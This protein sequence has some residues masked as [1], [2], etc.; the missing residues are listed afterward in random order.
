MKKI[1]IA[2]IAHSCRAGGSLLG[3]L[4]IIRALKNVVRGEQVLLICPAGYGFEEIKLPPDS[5]RFSYKGRHSPVQRCW[6]D[7]ITLPKLVAQYRPDVIF[8]ISNEGIRKPSVPQVLM[9]HNSYPLYSKKHCP[10]VSLKERLRFALL[11]SQI[12]KSLPSTQLVFTQTPVVKQR[13]ASSFSYPESQIKVLPWPVPSEIKPTAG[14]KLPSVFDKTS[15]IFYVLVLT[16]YMGHRS[17][18]VL[19]RLCRDF[20]GELR[21]QNIRFITTVEPDDYPGAKG[22]L[23]GITRNHLQDIITNVGSI[24]REEVLRYYSHSN[25]LWLPTLM[26]TLCLPYLEAVRMEVP[27]M[28][29]D[30]DFARY[31]CGEAA[32]YYD[33][34]DIESM[35]SGILLLR[36]NDALRK[37]LIEKGKKGLLDRERFSKSWEEVA[38]NIIRNLRQL[39]GQKL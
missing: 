12:R 31:V 17:P 2:V 1:K 19:I 8:S 3:T 10:E 33:P 30:L 32:V 16:R 23:K 25:L 14:L 39:A 4:S 24:S 22:F 26:E 21:E 27:I 18:G 29:P 9:F 34:W 37:E 20:G 35:F 15:D 38:D 36:K 13:L 5:E 7:T 6:F 11:K 28:A